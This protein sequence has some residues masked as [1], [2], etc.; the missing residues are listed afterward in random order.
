V[1]RRRKEWNN[2]I[3]RMTEDRI[4]RVVRDNSPKGKRRP[5]R[6]RK[7]WSDLLYINRLI[8]YQKD[9]RILQYRRTFRRVDYCSLDV[10][11]FMV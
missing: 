9:R 6:P 11:H 7:R 8:G 1:N 5:G 3:L 4:V 2:H 10:L